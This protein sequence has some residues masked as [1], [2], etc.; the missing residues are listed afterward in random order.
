MGR[1]GNFFFEELLDRSV[2][3]LDFVAPELFPVLFAAICGVF[4]LFTVSIVLLDDNLL[5]VDNVETT[6]TLPGD[7]STT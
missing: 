4:L 7:S 6:V 2:C 1:S 5:S 3:L